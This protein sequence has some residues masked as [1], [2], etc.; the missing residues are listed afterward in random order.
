MSDNLL[1]RRRKER[2]KT[3]SKE[4]LEQLK[5]LSDNFDNGNVGAYQLKTIKRKKKYI[6][7]KEIF[8][9]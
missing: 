9:Y 6:L 3:L 2:Y 4:K 8:L 7:K 5:L 1:L